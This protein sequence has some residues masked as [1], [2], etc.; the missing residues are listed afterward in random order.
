MLELDIE[1]VPSRL[2]VISASDCALPQL[3]STTNNL[4]PCMDFPPSLAALLLD[5]ILSCPLCRIYHPVSILACSVSQVSMRSLSTCSHLETPVGL[6]NLTESVMQSPLSPWKNR[7]SI[8]Q[9]CDISGLIC[10]AVLES[11]QALLW[12]CTLP[13]YAS[14]TSLPLAAQVWITACWL[15]FNC[16][17]F[18]PTRRA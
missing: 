14:P 8:L 5:R 13:D 7:V 12:A 2:V 6:H 3:S 11:I 9:Q 4:T 10:S 1:K 18:P 17:G 16:V 15:S